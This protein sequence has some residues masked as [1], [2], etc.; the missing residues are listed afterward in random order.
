MA[1]DVVKKITDT[2]KE[3]EELVKKAQALAAETQ[4][5]SKDEA[6]AIIESA[7]EKAEECYKN[8][9]SKYEREA[10]AASNPIIEESR[11]FRMKL[12]N[13]PADSMNRAVNMVIERIVNS[14]G[15][16]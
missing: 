4:K 7:K 8:T 13:I 6:E 14:H 2:E 3:G 12:T 15:N 11:N 5:K 9:I 10:S 16:S 1:F